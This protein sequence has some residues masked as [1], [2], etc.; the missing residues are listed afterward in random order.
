MED[1]VGKRILCAILLIFI[2]V[3]VGLQQPSAK[4][5]AAPGPKA[6]WTFMVYLDADNN[7]QPLHN[8]NFCWIKNISFR[9][10]FEKIFNRT[11]FVSS[12]T[13]LITTSHTS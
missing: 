10:K 9:Q 13:P 11:E 3:P 1:D 12:S 5:M 6:K 7:L 4:V 8:R 2:L